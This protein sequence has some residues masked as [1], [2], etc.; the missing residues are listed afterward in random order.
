MTHTY[1]HL[2]L[3]KVLQDIK[4]FVY[5]QGF[6]TVYFQDDTFF[7]NK[8][9]V[10]QLCRA[11]IR[12]KLNIQWK[13]N[14]R[15]NSL[16]DYSSEELGLLVDSGLFSLFIGAES[17]DQ[18][19]LN[20]MNKQ[21]QVN[22]V[23]KSA[24]IIRQYDIQ[25]QLSYIVGLPGDKPAYLRKTNDQI[26]HILDINQNVCFQICF[27]QPFP[28]T[29]LYQKALSIGYPRIKGLENWA[30]MKPQYK[31]TERLCELHRFPWL[32]ENE[33]GKYEKL[34]VELLENRSRLEALTNR[35]TNK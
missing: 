30:E 31:I 13:A 33:M 26:K 19:L 10:M 35:K 12:N 18:K 34:L 7:I 23:V 2:E 24:E 4:Y 6:R 16:I 22:D 29:T 8:N 11:L 27:Y 5:N 3:N 20:M 17:G 9:R 14:A 1:Y 25:L 28:G 15:A 32:S 21:I